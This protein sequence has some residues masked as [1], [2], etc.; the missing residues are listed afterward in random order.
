MVL[1]NGVV[2]ERSNFVMANQSQRQLVRVGFQHVVRC[3]TEPTFLVLR[4]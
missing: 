3:V 2:P 1:V 4:G